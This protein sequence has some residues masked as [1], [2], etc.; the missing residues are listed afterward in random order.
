MKM[1]TVDGRKKV[2]DID[3]K[4]IG[5]LAPASGDLACGPL[6]PVRSATRASTL[7]A[8]KG[9][10]NPS[11]LES[12]AESVVDQMM[13]NAIGKLAGPHLTRLWI[14]HHET[15]VTI[16]P[17]GAFFH[18]AVD[19]NDALGEVCLELD[20]CPCAALLASA[21]LIGMDDFFDT[22]IICQ[23]HHDG[24]R[25]GRTELLVLSLVL[26]FWMPSL[27]EFVKFWFQARPSPFLFTHPSDV[28]RW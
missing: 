4:N 24:L 18:P 28:T 26:A 7:N 2:S 16:R 1:L 9:R 20:G 15:H 11:W 13:N 14:H 3:L 21:A 25:T 8:G 27:P 10:R 19:I 22:K 5:R 6:G 17:P 12:R 23:R